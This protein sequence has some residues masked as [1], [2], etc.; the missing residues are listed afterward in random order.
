MST[1]FNCLCWCDCFII[2][3]VDAFCFVDLHRS[4]GRLFNSLLQLLCLDYNLH[5]RLLDENLLFRLIYRPGGY[6]TKFC[7][8]MLRPEI[9]TLG[10]LHV[11]TTFDQ[12]GTDMI[13][14]FLALFYTSTREIASVLYT[15]SL[16][17]V[18]FLGGAPSPL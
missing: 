3:F 15:S 5:Y 14:V 2:L 13:K 17:N 6:L 12:I 10:L 4:I 16:K 1:K 18:L 7:S 8:G 11:Y 9:Q